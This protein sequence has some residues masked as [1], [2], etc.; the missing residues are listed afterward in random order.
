MTTASDPPPPETINW[1]LALTSG[2][3]ATTV[4]GLFLLALKHGGNAH[5]SR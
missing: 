4:V 5:K 3:A 1:A 2:L